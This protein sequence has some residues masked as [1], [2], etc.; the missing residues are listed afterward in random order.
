MENELNTWIKDTK[1]KGL[2]IQ[3]HDN[4]YGTL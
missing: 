3:L 2:K 1:D 4:V